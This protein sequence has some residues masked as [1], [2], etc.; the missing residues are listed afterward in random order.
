M[1]MHSYL[2]AAESVAEIEKKQPREISRKVSIDGVCAEEAKWECAGGNHPC[3]H[4]HFHVLLS[5][6][7]ERILQLTL[8]RIQRQ[9]LMKRQTTTHGIFQS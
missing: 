5:E 6:R 3:G 9:I 7:E 1:H 8:L 2:T 4:T